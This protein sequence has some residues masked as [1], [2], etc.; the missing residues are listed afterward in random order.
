MLSEHAVPAVPDEPSADQFSHFAVGIPLQLEVE[1]SARKM[2]SV[3]VG[4]VP[5][6]CV[7]VKHPSTGGGISDGLFAGSKVVVRYRIDEDVFG[8][9]SQL[10][11]VT[12]EPIKLLFLDY[13]RFVARC[14]LRGARRMPLSLPAQL[15]V[16]RFGFTGCIPGSVHAGVLR[17]ISRSGCCFTMGRESDRASSP[18]ALEDKVL[19]RL[20]LPGNES[21]MDIPGEARR[22][23]HDSEN[24]T[25]GIRFCD[26]DP[27]V[28]KEVLRYVSAVEQYDG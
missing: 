27:R 26:G 19:L 2:T 25:V 7:I 17:D 5:G 23:E 13:P 11:G 3:S 24:S 22:I 16:T 14:D 6:K 21:Q 15:L 1:G 12:R 10:I 18:L 20:Q 8:F 28:S 4:Y 9:R